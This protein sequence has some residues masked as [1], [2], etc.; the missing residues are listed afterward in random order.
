MKQRYV[1]WIPSLNRRELKVIALIT[2]VSAIGVAAA[3]GLIMAIEYI[4]GAMHYPLR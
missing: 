4:L 2:I 3:M 1:F